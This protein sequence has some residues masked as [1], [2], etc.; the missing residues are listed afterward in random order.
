MLDPRPQPTFDES[1]AETQEVMAYVRSI[2]SYIGD[3]PDREGLLDTPRRVVKAMHEHFWGYHAD[4]MEPLQKTFSEI[5]GYDELVL[6]QDI[7]IQSHCEHHMVPFVG[8]AH[9]AYIPNGKVVGLSKLARVVEIYSKRLQVQEKLTAQIAN[10]IQETLKPHGVAV[11]LQCRHFCMC[12]RGV[13]QPRAWTTTSKLHGLFL[14]D[15]AA[16]T[17]LFTLISNRPSES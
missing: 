7:D 12:Y 3:D 16:R 10:A 13:Q 6:L 8:K 5:E 2:L 11:I 17:E 15:P 9:V 1:S 14:N 4:P